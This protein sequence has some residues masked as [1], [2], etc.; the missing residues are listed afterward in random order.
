[1]LLT[2][3]AVVVVEHCSVLSNS[4][5]VVTAVTAAID[6]SIECLAATTN[7]DLAVLQ[8]THQQSLTII[9]AY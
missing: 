9:M 6:T 1:V 8:S 4:V 3:T 5:A 2:T 7:I